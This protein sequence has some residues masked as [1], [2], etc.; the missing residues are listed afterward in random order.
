[1]PSSAAETSFATLMPAI[2]IVIAAR[3]VGDARRA[4]AH[5]TRLI[6]RYDG[7][8]LFERGEN[9]TLEA[10]FRSGDEL[11][12]AAFELEEILAARAAKTGSSASSLDR[13]VDGHTR[14]DGRL[15]LVRPLHAYGELVGALALR[16]DDRAVLD[17]S[18]FAAL[19]RFCEFAAPMLS[20]ARTRADLDAFAYT[21]PLTGLANRR[22]LERDFKRLA[23]TRLALLF[24]DFDGLKAVN[25]TLGYAEGDMLIATIGAALGELARPGELIVRYGGDEFVVIIEDAG[26]AQA[27]N[28]ADEITM[29][30]D[31]LSIPPPFAALFQGASVGW[32]S[33]EAGDAAAGAL[34][35]AAAEMRSRKRRRK[36]DREL[37]AVVCDAEPL[38]SAKLQ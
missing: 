12:S 30:L 31:R 8:T 34:A 20:S 19:Q 23:D 35:R 9:G 28:R 4:I 38:R 6:S 21:D 17:D 15:C 7:L 10:T 36:T 25:D 14:T 5:G 3:D 16:Y 26:A 1:M 33:V 18:E 13:T 29:A 11:E 22:R 27:R 24:V 2:Q 37:R 32:A